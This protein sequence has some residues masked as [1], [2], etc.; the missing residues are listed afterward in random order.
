MAR[1]LNR[2][3][4]ASEPQG[5]PNGTADQATVVVPALSDSQI[6]PVAEVV[7]QPA[8]EQPTTAAP[9]VEGAAAPAEGDGPAAKEGETTT[10]DAP[11]AAG[12]PAEADAPTGAVA[13]AREV[14]ARVDFRSRSRLRRRLR[15]LRR[16]R[17]IGFRDL[18]GLVFDLDRFGRDRPDLVELK[19]QGMRSIDAELRALEIALDDVHEFEELHEPGLTSCAHCGA[20][21]GSDAN[22]CPSCGNP[23]GSVPQPEPAPGEAPPAEAVTAGPEARTAVQPPAD[24]EQPAA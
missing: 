10:A 8:A 4:D 3:T 15:Y 12:D 18:G 17:E 19:L 9:A 22:F 14:P 5:S 1:I 16:V 13:A 2:R 20:L 7:E 6:A 21:H 11:P 23:A 24:P